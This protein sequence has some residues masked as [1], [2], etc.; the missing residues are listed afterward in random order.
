MNKYAL[1][2]KI[3]VRLSG[4]KLAE[5]RRRWALFRN[6]PE[7]AE[8]FL[9]AAA[10][11]VFPERKAKPLPTTPEASWTTDE[12]ELIR[13]FLANRD[14]LPVQGLRLSQCETVTR[15]GAARFY[16]FMAD[17]ASGSPG[18]GRDTIIRHLRAIENHNEK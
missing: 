10:K 7:K 17:A 12:A 5:F 14:A 16:A 1:K 3:E 8:R 2:T 4:S 15:D 11:V 9:T 18:P 13:W 6:D